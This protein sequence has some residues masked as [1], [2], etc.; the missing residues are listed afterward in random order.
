MSLLLALLANPESGR[1]KALEAERELRELGAEVLRFDLDRA[2]DAARSR[3]ARIAVAGGDGSIAPAAC[4]AGEAGVPLAVIPVG[5]ANDF[6]RAIGIPLEASEASRLA[7]AG[8]Q[9]RRLDLAWMG[10]R[11]F[12]NVAS[13]GLAPVAAR[14][15]GGLKRILGPLSYSAGAVR[16]AARARPIR[17]R[18]HCD[19]DLYFDGRAWQVSVAASGAFGGGA[20]V[21]AD[22]GDGELDVVVFRAGSRARL[23]G[24]AYRLRA[25]GVRVR[26]GVHAARCREIGVDAENGGFNV[27][28]EL[29]EVRQARFRIEPRAFEVVTG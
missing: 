27:D 14:H 8:T 23:I 28:G 29:V 20:S 26:P 3:A 4:A 22:P 10:S 1:G 16:A 19:R 5:T 24:H 15:A 25:G 11:P 12:V 18:V 13:A 6:A 21:E 7:V 9:T 2:R 17:C